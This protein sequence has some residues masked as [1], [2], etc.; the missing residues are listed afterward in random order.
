MDWVFS[1]LGRNGF[2]PHGYCFSW[3]PGLLWTMVGADALIALAYFSIP[4]T[5]VSFLRKRGGQ[6]FQNQVAWLFSAFIFA[7]GVTHVMDIWTIWR[8]DYALS[9][10]V[11]VLTAAISVMTAV[12]I[13]RLVP[14]ALQIPT[15]GQLQSAIVALQAEV[16]QRKSAQQNLADTEQSLSVTLASIDAGFITADDSGRVTSMNAIAEKITGW[17]L[18][19]AHG[20]SLWEVFVREGREAHVLQRNPVDVMLEL[21]VTIEQTHHVVGIAK[22]GQRTALEV[23]AA[24]KHAP[25]GSVRG[26]VMVLRDMTRINSA[27]AAQR[28]LA[29]IVASSNDAIIG[30]TLDGRITD[31]NQA[32]QSM[33]GYTEN[34]AIGQPIQ[35]LIPP[36]RAAEEMRIVS[37]LAAGRVVPPFETVRQARDGRKV[38]VSIT[39]SPIRDALGRIIGASKIARDVSSQRLAEMALRNSRE[40]QRL[41]E[42][43][44]LK[45]EK[46]EAENRQIQESSRLKSQFLANMSHE[47]RTPLNAIIGF[48][49]LLRSGAVPADSPKQSE[50]L[51]HIGSSGRHLLQLINDVLDLSKV[52]S[53]KFEFF[54]EVVEL[55]SLVNEVRN[56][57]Q[58]ALTKKKLEMDVTIDPEVTWLVIDARRLKQVLYNYLSNAIKFTPDGGHIS[59]RATPQDA[60]CFRIEVQDTGIGIA[61]SELQRLFVE[62]QQL[63]AGHSRQHAGTGLGLALTRR[64]VQAQGGSVGV[65]STLNE[66]SVFHLVLP[67]DATQ[68]VGP[69][70]STQG[71]DSDGTHRWLLVEDRPAGDSVLLQGLQRIGFHVDAVS[72]ADQALQHARARPYDAISLDLV[73]P[74]ASGLAAL[75]SIRSE[76]GPNQTSPVVTVAMPTQPGS[77]AVFAIADLLSKPING[78]E[79]VQ[80]MS[81]YSLLGGATAKVMVIDDDPVAIDL[82]RATLMSVGIESICYTDAR[83]AL[84]NLGQHQPDAM[85]LDLMMPGFDGFAVLD[86]LSSMPEWHH[87]PVF[88]WTSM[89]LTDEEHALLARSAHAILG[90]GGGAL[91]GVLERL[92][93][94]QPPV[95]LRERTLP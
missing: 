83:L 52:E 90:K 53:G 79:V 37:D 7:C 68:T 64:L 59:V 74:E 77:A 12:L 73:L 78:D 34:E 81:R 41:A 92:Q 36:E 50:F 27:E 51:G 16:M 29:A 89:I 38:E 11:K 76:Q 65:R 15:V 57:L 72:T 28:R 23:K 91:Q 56:I 62:F 5:I 40:Q 42:L 32:A 66:G 8:P 6:A 55:P 71:V 46:L 20:R 95:A 30:K 61:E 93:R 54:A 47:L 86:A 13:W 33:F 43:A 3:S 39:I 24:V 84:Q 4:V 58:T 80:A 19:E 2:L 60:H 75:S 85:V 48:S 1:L 26:V 45:A 21:G 14:R 63:D 17:S 10:F 49:D 67:R 25:D 88:V 35:M 44:T 87:L 9:A 70:T 18:A 69:E 82:M 94:W 31:W 22:N